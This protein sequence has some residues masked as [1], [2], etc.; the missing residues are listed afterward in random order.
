MLN[1]EDFLAEL[2]G[3]Q[4]GH[5]QP[6]HIGQNKNG[7]RLHLIGP[8]IPSLAAATWPASPRFSTTTRTPNFRSMD[9]R[10]QPLSQVFCAIGQGVAGVDSM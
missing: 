8:C 3:E 7:A 9:R 6:S 1:F 2:E 4:D 5:S 10:A